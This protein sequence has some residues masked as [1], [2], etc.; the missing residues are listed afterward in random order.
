MPQI[1]ISRLLE[2]GRNARGGAKCLLWAGNN[3]QSLRIS[4]V[5]FFQAP[6]QF[7]DNEEVQSELTVSDG[8]RTK[9][10]MI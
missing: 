9:M 8:I 10:R 7:Q 6:A 1:S 4:V 2:V 5:V 3:F